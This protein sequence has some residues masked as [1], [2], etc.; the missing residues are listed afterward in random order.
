MATEKQQAP[1]LV[2]PNKFVRS[3]DYRDIYSNH[4]RLTVSSSDISIIFSKIIELSYGVNTIEDN[5]NIRLSPQQ[6]KAFVDSA[7]KTLAA[8]EEVF[9]EVAPATKPQSKD[10]IKEGIRRL[11][12]VLDGEK[13]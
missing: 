10:S 3:P 8:W 2:D 4:V 1:V 9:G 7:S 11:K 5:V 13:C 12:S 6:C